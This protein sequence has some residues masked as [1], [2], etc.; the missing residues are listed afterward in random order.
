VH[1]CTYFDEVVKIKKPVNQR[2]TGF[3]DVL[4]CFPAVRE[5]IVQPLYRADNQYI[6]QIKFLTHQNTHY[7]FN[8]KLI[9][10]LMFKYGKYFRNVQGPS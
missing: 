7:L 9:A 4:I 2:F 10:N 6:M 3:L 1:F 5:G 8:N